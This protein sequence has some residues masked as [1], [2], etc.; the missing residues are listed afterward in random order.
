MKYAN[1]RV[2]ISGLG[3]DEIMGHFCFYGEGSPHEFPEKINDIFPWKNF[4]EGSQRNYLDAFEK[5]GGSLGYE[6]RYPFLDTNVVQEFLSL[7]HHLKN[8]QVKPAVQS[9][10]KLNNFP[11]EMNAKIGINV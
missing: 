4:F 7:S 5:C 8:N 1:T 9:Y 10:L 11:F 2:L 6:F 3:S